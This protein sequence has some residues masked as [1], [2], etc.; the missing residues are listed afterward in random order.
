MKYI[1]AIM[2]VLALAGCASPQE[3]AQSD[4][5]KCRAN[6][7]KL[8]TTEYDKCRMT[9][10]AAHQQQNLAQAMRQQAEMQR[11]SAEYITRMGRM[12]R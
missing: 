11:Q 5:Q 8:G 6:G 12:T 1:S 7:F 10:D 4:D 3:I 9:L 2:A